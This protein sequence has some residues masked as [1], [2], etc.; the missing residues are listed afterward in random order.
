MYAYTA[1]QWVLFFLF[2]C[3]AGWCIESIFVSVRTRR[4]VNRGFLYG[5]AIPIY[6]FGAIAIL[7]ATLP[8]RVRP[9]LVFLLGMAAATVLEYVTGA[10]M[11]AIF[12]VRYWDYTG[13]PFNLHGYICLNTSLAWGVL[14][15]VLVL[16][17]HKPVERVV[18]SFPARLTQW[19]AVALGAVFL[20]DTVLSAKAAL[21]LR[22]LLRQMAQHAESA[23]ESAR[24]LQKRLEVAAVFRLDDFLH[25]LPDG[26]EA[27]QAHMEALEDAARRLERSDAAEQLRADLAL[28]RIRRAVIREGIRQRL[29]WE[30]RLRLKGNPSAR[31]RRYAEQLQLLRQRVEE[32]RKH[33]S[34]RK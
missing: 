29:T 25:S 34:S 14:S 33:R 8:V 5:P 30:H 18:L 11:E 16:W 24:L 3:L 13:K 7:F 17:L 20:T 27:L 4:L 1:P 26:G 6:G 12:Q 32:D 23:R 10:V 2:Y 9:A 19:L 21:D 31:S 15:I 22:Q 28:W